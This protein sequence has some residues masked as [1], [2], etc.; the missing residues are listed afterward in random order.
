M[1]VFQR[2]MPEYEHHL[3]AV[4]FPQ[5]PDRRFNGTADRALK[6]T[7]FDYGDPGVLRPGPVIGVRYRERQRGC[8]V[9]HVHLQPLCSL[10]AGTQG[11][12]SWHR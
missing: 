4:Q 8:S 3:L 6:V 11:H 12:K 9:W 2:K 1:R 5:L 10:L 7:I